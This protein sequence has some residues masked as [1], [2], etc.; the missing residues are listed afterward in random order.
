MQRNKEHFLTM[1][2]KK[3]SGSRKN[4]AASTTTNANVGKEIMIVN[5]AFPLLKRSRRPE[6]VERLVRK[7]ELPEEAAIL[8]ES[9]EAVSK[10]SERD[11]HGSFV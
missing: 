5:L 1:E 8:A 7:E 6:T 10:V 11:S 4:L 3:A 2:N 9:S